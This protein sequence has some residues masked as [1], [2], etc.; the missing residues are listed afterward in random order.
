MLAGPADDA[1]LLCCRGGV[2]PH[3]DAVAA[4]YAAQVAAGTVA[5]ADGA[6]EILNLQ[7]AVD[8]FQRDREWAG[9]GFGVARLLGLFES[10]DNIAESDPLA[11]R[12]VDAAI[13]AECARLAQVPD[14]VV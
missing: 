4:Y 8:E 9:D 1:R 11:W 13:V 5:P 14:G 12:D 3:S 6:S 7:S 2:G 10:Y